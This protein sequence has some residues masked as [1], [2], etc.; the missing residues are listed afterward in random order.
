MGVGPTGK[1]F[2]VVPCVYACVRARCFCLVEL[3]RKRGSD[4]FPLPSWGAEL[5]L[6]P[7]GADELALLL[8]PLQTSYP[9]LVGLMGKRDNIGTDNMWACTVGSMSAFNLLSCGR[10]RLKAL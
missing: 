5:C 3:D 6:F 1:L 4:L 10:V 9:T 7:F 2:C 8:P